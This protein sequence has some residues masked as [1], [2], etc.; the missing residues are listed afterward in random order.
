MRSIVLLVPLLCS[1]AALADSDADKA[2]RLIERVVESRERLKTASIDY[3]ITRS[4][5]TPSVRLLVRNH[6]LDLAASGDARLLDLGDDEGVTARTESGEPAP[7][8][9]HGARQALRDGQSL[10]AN[11]ETARFPLAFA[12][13]HPNVI[14]PDPRALGLSTGLA[15]VGVR[16]ALDPNKYGPDPKWTVV[17]DGSLTCVTLR[18]ADAMVRR[19]IDR[20]RDWNI[21]RIEYQR[22]ATRREA[23]VELQK[24]DGVWFP[25]E[26]RIYNRAFAESAEPT[27]VITIARAE[28]NRP[29]HARDFSVGDIGIRDGDTVELW[30]RTGPTGRTGSVIGGEFVTDAELAA[31]QDAEREGQPNRLTAGRVQSVL[32]KPESLWERVVRQFIEKHRLD[33]EQQQQCWRILRDCQSE[34]HSHLNRKRSELLAAANAVDAMRSSATPGS[35]DQLAAAEQALA[36][37]T[38]PIDRILT[39]RLQPR[40]D[41]IPTT[42]QRKNTTG[43]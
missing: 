39:D 20:D 23:R 3:R 35:K 34:A 8:G 12:A 7:R 25:S 10:W 28:F 21:V 29:E 26:V 9:A 32:A 16:D 41:S 5:I 4:T 14:V 43:K 1:S 18:T 17:E 38:A 24:A 2:L 27:E 42:A 19:W 37:L 13:D 22:G 36:K 30:D 40:L 15:Y 6:T 33:E 31:R 11:E